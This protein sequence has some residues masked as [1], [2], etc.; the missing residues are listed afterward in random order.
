MSELKKMM[1]R[2]RSRNFPGEWLDT[3][4]KYYEEWKNENCGGSQT[5]ENRNRNNG[6]MYYP[7]NKWKWG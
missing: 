3:E 2:E 1:Q 4:N 7:N 5:I 6:Y